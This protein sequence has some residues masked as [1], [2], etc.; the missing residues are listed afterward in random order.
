M[1]S[2]KTQLKK[3]EEKRKLPRNESCKTHS[4]ADVGRRE[5]RTVLTA[6]TDRELAKMMTSLTGPLTYRKSYIW[7][8]EKTYFCSRH[9]LK[10]YTDRKT[11]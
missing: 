8:Q 7:F 4:G 9:S 10:I 11:N 6:K 2:G 5:G 1:L 3:R